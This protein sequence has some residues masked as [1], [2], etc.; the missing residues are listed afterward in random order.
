MGATLFSGSA[1]IRREPNL[2]AIKDIM[3]TGANPSVIFPKGTL[4]FTFVPL[5]GNINIVGVEPIILGV[6]ARFPTNEEIT[7]LKEQDI[8]KVGTDINK[9]L[10]KDNNKGLNNDD[11]STKG[12]S[13]NNKISIGVGVIALIGLT[14]YLFKKK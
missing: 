9:A 5:G 7:I 6:N 3:Y 11:S 14:L 10:A 8:F 4:F 2:I 13:L 1:G 12:M